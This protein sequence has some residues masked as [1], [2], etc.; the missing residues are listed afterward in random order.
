MDVKFIKVTSVIRKG[1]KE[2]LP[3]YTHGQTVKVLGLPTG[4][5]GAIALN[6]SSL[7]FEGSYDGTAFSTVNDFAGKQLVIPAKAD[8]RVIPQNGLVPAPAQ[9]PIREPVLFDGLLVVRPVSDV[10]QTEDRTIDIYLG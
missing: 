5:T 9:L 7:S 1:E 8:Q 4:K 10:I 2:G 6:G 3:V